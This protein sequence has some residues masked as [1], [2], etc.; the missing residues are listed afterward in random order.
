MKICLQLHTCDL[1]ICLQNCT[2]KPGQ[3]QAVLVTYLHFF[4][5]R[6]QILLV[7]KIVLSY[8]RS[9]EITEDFED[10]VSTKFKEF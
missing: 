2:I 6:F 9:L 4:S 8:E 3:F 1:L 5:F 7:F 10:E